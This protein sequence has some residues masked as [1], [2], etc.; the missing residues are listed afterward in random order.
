[1]TTFILLLLLGS[2][3]SFAFHLTFS[4]SVRS[5]PFYLL[6]GIGGALVGYT[7]A[8]LLGWDWLLVGGLPVLMTLVGSIVFLTL[9]RRIRFD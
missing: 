6:T 3:C 8:Q 9:A 2:I 4:S 5:I 1:M 7:V